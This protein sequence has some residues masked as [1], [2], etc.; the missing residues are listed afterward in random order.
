MS[1]VVPEQKNVRFSD[2]IEDGLQ[3]VHGVTMENIGLFQ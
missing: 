2:T 3:A 1:T